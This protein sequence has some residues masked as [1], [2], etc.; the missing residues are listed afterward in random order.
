MNTRVNRKPLLPNVLLINAE[1]TI[2]RLAADVKRLQDALRV[3]I[4]GPDGCR[5]C[6]LCAYY[7]R[8]EMD[9]PCNRCS[10]GRRWQLSS[11]YEGLLDERVDI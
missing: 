8:P 6:E 9:Y 4:A 3:S 1:D 7:N 10:N 5:A 11:H 2:I